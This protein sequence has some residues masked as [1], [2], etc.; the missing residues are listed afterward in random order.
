MERVEQVL[1]PAFGWPAATQHRDAGPATG[2]MVVQPAKDV[3]CQ[4]QAQAVQRV[5]DEVAQVESNADP[6]PAPGRRQRVVGF[7]SR[8]PTSRPGGR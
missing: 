6:R 1:P 4:Q 7:G 5:L 2:E 3:G 8:F